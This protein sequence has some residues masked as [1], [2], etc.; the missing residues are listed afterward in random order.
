MQII[1][2]IEPTSVEK[3]A[4][5][6][7]WGNLTVSTEAIRNCVNRIMEYK[8]PRMRQCTLCLRHGQRIAYD[9]R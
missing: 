1:T 7:H 2:G 6:L 9:K 3:K 4:Q 8:S 5:R